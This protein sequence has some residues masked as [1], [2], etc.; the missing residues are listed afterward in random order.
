MIRLRSMNDTNLNDR[1]KL[2][3]SIFKEVGNLTREELT[4]HLTGKIK[5]SRITIIR[6]LNYLITNKLVKTEGKGKNTIYSLY[7]ANP[8]LTYLDLNN[9][10][11]KDSVERIINKRFNID[12]FNHLNNLYSQN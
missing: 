9:Y 3:L 8:S 11:I 4:I 6:D 10:F 7:E 1:Q 12:V 2:I 5:A